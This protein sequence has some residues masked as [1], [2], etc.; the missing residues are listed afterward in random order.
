MKQLLQV[1]GGPGKLFLT[2]GAK[3]CFGGEAPKKKFLRRATLAAAQVV[4]IMLTVG[5]R[6]TDTRSWLKA[7]TLGD[8]AQ[9]N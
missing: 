8:G 5:F 3:T 6:R 2:V 4:G 9:L 1:V 7:A